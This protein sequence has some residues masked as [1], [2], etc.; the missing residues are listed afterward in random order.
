MVSMMSDID[1]SVFRAR[2]QE[3]SALVFKGIPIQ[4]LDAFRAQ[5]SKRGYKLRWRGPRA[6][7]TDR[8]AWLRQSVCTRED[9]TYFSVYQYAR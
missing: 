5:Y 2:G 6:H 8:P 1:F 3:T 9:A 7:R 4:Y